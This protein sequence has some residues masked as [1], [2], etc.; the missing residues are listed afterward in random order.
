MATITFNTDLVLV[1]CCNCGMHFAMPKD[2]TCSRRNDHKWFCCPNG[3]HQHFTTKTRE[4]KLTEE[5][6]E[7][8][9]AREFWET[10]EACARTERDA[11]ERRVIGQKAAKTRIKNR[12]AR[13][14]CPCCNR[15]FR[16]LHRHMDT[17]HPDWV[18]E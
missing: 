18:S 3:H 6:D 10:R 4:Q 13:G 9:R 2:F 12:I 1:E 17:K 15:T 14:V 11:A 16:D 8:R 5:R 7:E